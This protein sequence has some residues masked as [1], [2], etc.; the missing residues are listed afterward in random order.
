MGAIK[1]LERGYFH[2]EIRGILE[3]EEVHRGFL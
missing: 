3:N 2:A 1:G